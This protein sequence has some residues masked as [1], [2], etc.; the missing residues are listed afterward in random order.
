MFYYIFILLKVIKIIFLAA[1]V[2]EA[3]YS[4]QKQNQEL[5]RAHI[6]NSLMQN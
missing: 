5:T 3:I 6:M 4:Q 2:G 1:K